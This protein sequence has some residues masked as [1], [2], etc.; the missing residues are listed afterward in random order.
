VHQ[1]HADSDPG[2]TPHQGRSDY[3][4]E[5]KHSGEPLTRLNLSRVQLDDVRI[6]AHNN[7]FGFTFCSL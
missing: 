5:S 2:S 7:L 4:S 6:V 1:G 3:Q